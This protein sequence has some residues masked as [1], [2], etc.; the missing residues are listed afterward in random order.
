MDGA[1]PNPAYRAVHDRLATY[2]RF[3]VRLGLEPIQ[4]I[5]EQLGHPQAQVPIIHV[6]GTNGKGS[7]CAY[8]AAIL[9]AAGYQT[10]CYTSPHLQDWTERISLNQRAIAPE[11]LLDLLLQ[12]EQVIPQIAYSPSQFEL[13]TAAAWLYFA[14]ENV[15]IAIIEVGLGG[16]LDAT[17]VCPTPLVAVIT[18]IGWDHWQR[19]GST[20]GAIAQEKAG[21][22]KPGGNAVIGP[23]PAE[24]AA[25]IQNRLTLLKNTAIWPEPAQWVCAPDSSD[26]R[27]WAQWRTYTYPLVLAGDM[28]RINSSLALAAVDLLKEQGWLLSDPA[29]VEGMGRTFWPGRLQ[30]L[31][32]QGKQFLID[33]AH[34]QPAAIALREYVDQQRGKK[35]FA[36][37]DS[38][39]WILAILDN[40]DHEGILTA[41]LRPGD[42][43]YVV[44]IPEHSCADPV[45]LQALGQRL[46]PGLVR[47]DVFS[48]WQ[49]ALEH[50]L[51]LPKTNSLTVLAGSLYLVGQV[52]RTFMPLEK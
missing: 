27:L 21:I 13:L 15:D 29:I 52:L 5:L 43:L 14:Q 24:A 4:A 18:S 7:V 17:N 11:R 1:F 36:D 2:S 46:C 51:D 45:A 30:W 10:G 6:A 31:T 33:G 32:D 3:G 42:R 22:L 35:T 26:A 8:L 48:D 47:C 23:V 19:L 9:T 39:T 16:R 49:Q 40:K 20:L 41:L 12:V 38:V 37:H 34:N 25:V 28:Q 50:A 44:P